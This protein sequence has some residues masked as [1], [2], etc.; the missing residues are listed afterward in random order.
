MNRISQRIAAAVAGVRCPGCG[1]VV[2]PV[3]VPVMAGEASRAAGGEDRW[4][5]LWRAPSGPVCPEC[6]FPLG[7][8]ARR[9][10]WIRLLLTGVVL[11]TISLLLLVVGMMGEGSRLWWMVQRT[12]GVVGLAVLSTGLGGV[13][14]GRR[15][16]PD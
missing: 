11:V 4:S 2:M 1:K 5:F 16:K 8:Y 15:R 6:S 13:I 10:K 9:V 14:I 7:R 3:E 12:V